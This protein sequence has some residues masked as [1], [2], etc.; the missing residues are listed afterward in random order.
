MRRFRLILLLFLLFFFF[1]YSIM[2]LFARF[3]CFV[4][5]R[6]LH[7][8][9]FPPWNRVP[10]RWFWF[11]TIFVRTIDAFT[12]LKW[13]F[14]RSCI[15]FMEQKKKTMNIQCINNNLTHRLCSPS[16]HIA[17]VSYVMF[18]VFGPMPIWW[19]VQPTFVDI[20]CKLISKT[21][22]KMIQ[23]NSAYGTVEML[24]CCDWNWMSFK[25]HLN[26]SHIVAMWSTVA[27][28]NQIND[29]IRNIRRTFVADKCGAN[30]AKN[31]QP[32]DIK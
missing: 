29:S 19:L 21:F 13:D 23:S 3:C 24:K 1:L 4:F 7:S 22:L 11:I 27:T 26:K 9:H 30:Y 15:Y 17:R 10:F 5:R 28:T 31:I 20:F 16:N 14:S 8:I 18:D 2:E 32:Q 12:S 6:S 25:S